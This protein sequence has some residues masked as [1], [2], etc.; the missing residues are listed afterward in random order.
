MI[1]VRRMQRASVLAL[2]LFAVCAVHAQP[3]PAQRI[4]MH[5]Y[6]S[7]SGAIVISLIDV[8]PSG[9][10]RILASSPSTRVRH[11]LSHAEFERMWTTLLASGARKLD[12]RS[13]AK[14]V[15]GANNYV[16]SLADVPRITGKRF[17]IPKTLIVASNDASPS[18]VAVAR[19]I[20][21]AA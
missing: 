16:F 19:K 3:K 2:Y 8:L 14:T 11:S 10:V 18:V 13:P 21:G 15:D 7:G 20:P 5:T 1:L 12:A 4:L 17:V 9:P 6:G